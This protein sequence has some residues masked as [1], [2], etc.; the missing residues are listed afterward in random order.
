MG[1]IGDAAMSFLRR[2]VHPRLFDLL[3]PVLITGILL[4]LINYAM[5]YVMGWLGTSASKTILNDLII[6]ILGSVAVF[7]SILASY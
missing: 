5:D 3:R 4:C 6:G 7:Y 1:S 2:T